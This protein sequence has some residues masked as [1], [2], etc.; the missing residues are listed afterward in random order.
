MRSPKKPLMQTTAR[1]P[2]S[3]R[4]ATQA[5]MPAEPVPD[6]AMVCSFWVRKTA[7]RRSLVSSMIFRKSGSRWPRTGA[8]MA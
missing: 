1:S 4:L 8:I 6:T 5:S 3:M 7:R 2:G